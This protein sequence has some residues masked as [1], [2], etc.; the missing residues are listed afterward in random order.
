[1]KNSRGR[2]FGGTMFVLGIALGSVGCSSMGHWMMTPPEPF[3][4]ADAPPAPD[5][6]VA[7]SWAALPGEPSRAD[8]VPPNDGERFFAAAEG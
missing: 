4:A 5:Y 7:A 6:T 8:S 1:M 2:R 3:D